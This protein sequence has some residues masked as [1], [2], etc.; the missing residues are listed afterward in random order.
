MRVA[1]V[2]KSGGDFDASHVARLK[3]QVERH[4]PGADFVCLSDVPVPCAR[5][6]LIAG[7]S[8]W[9]SKLELFRLPS[10]I[11]FDLDTSIIASLADIAAYPHRFTALEHW[12][13]DGRLCSGFMAWNGDYSYLLDEFTKKDH[14]KYARCMG[15]WGD[16]GYIQD[17]LRVQPEWVNTLFPGCM[18]S[19]KKHCR[20][21]IPAGTRVIYFHGKPRPWE[22]Q[23]YAA[24]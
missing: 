6:P 13:R 8:G 12:D 15:R 17:H 24:A 10:A 16:Q 22:T 5:I 2:L 14:L 1:C 7:L 19:Y 3:T 11:Y 21:S 23:T 4:L 18:M 9:W 20:E